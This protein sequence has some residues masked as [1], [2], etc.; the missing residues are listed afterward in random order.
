M[1]A[2]ETFVRS[3]RFGA[4]FVKYVFRS[5]WSHLFLKSFDSGFL[6][7]CER[8]HWNKYYALSDDR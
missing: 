1:T 7:I 5:D 3:L 6:F 2:V 4:S 8:C